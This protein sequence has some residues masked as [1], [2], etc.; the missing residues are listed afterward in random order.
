MARNYR[1]YRKKR[2]TNKSRS[3]NKRKS[4]RGPN[5]IAILFIVLLVAVSVWAISPLSERFKKKQEVSSVEKKISLIK[6]QNKLLEEELIR[7]Q[8]DDYIEQLA[9]RHLFL[10]KPGE[11]VYSVVWPDDKNKPEEKKDKELKNTENKNNEENIW[12]RIKEYFYK[13]KDAI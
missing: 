11:S 5:L 3:R 10:T 4:Y 6:K 1:N 8:A 12:E 2:K 13:L 7:L 9:R